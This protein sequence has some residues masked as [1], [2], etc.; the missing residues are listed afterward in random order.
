MAIDSSSSTRTSLCSEDCCRSR[1]AIAS[2][3]LT[4]TTS[5]GVVS[6]YVITQQALITRIAR[7]EADA[8][9]AQRKRDEEKGGK[10]DVR[11]AQTSNHSSLILMHTD[12]SWRIW[13]RRHGGFRR[14]VCDD[15][16]REVASNCEAVH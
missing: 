13:V 9:A 15:E 7:A 8:E 16:V 1:W 5:T 3:T 2:T 14:Q 10:Y 4:C 12:E 6:G 11:L